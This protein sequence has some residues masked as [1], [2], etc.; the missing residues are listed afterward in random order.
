[1]SI[2][3]PQ[4]QGNYFVI[5]LLVDYC[6]RKKYLNISVKAVFMNSSYKKTINST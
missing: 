3:K 1:M 4:L 2:G 5:L 6:V